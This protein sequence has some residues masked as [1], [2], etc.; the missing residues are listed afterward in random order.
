MHHW[1]F[2]NS[3]RR[4]M[5]TP[6]SSSASVTLKAIAWLAM[7]GNIWQS[8]QTQCIGKSS[9]EEEEDQ[10]YPDAWQQTSIRGCVQVPECPVSEYLAATAIFLPVTSPAAAEANSGGKVDGFRGKSAFN[11]IGIGSNRDVHSTPMCGAYVTCISHGDPAAGMLHSATQERTAY[12]LATDV[13][14][15]SQEGSANN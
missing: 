5:R 4:R 6:R 3:R 11:F 12:P 15:L 13:A 14:L 8:N 2:S 7:A 9:P 10:S 1:R